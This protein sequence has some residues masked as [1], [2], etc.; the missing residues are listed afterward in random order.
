MTVNIDNIL[1]SISSSYKSSGVVN[2]L[3]LSKVQLLTLRQVKW[4]KCIVKSGKLTE[5]IRN[6]FLQN[7]KPVAKNAVAEDNQSEEDDS[8]ADK[9]K[10]AAMERAAM[11][12]AG[13]ET[14][15]MKRAAMKRVAMK[16]AEITFTEEVEAMTVE[17]VELRGRPFNF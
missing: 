16:R 3:D 5:K 7:L 8:R 2:D 13:M 12:R 4:I 11:K 10:R 6:T 15:G 9:L 1:S 17:Q 14:V